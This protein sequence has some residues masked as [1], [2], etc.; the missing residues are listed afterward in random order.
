MDGNRNS[1]QVFRLTGTVDQ[2][3]RARRLVS[4]ALGREHPLHDDCVLLTSELATNAVVHSH[5][6]DG[7]VFT[8]TVS[9]TA[10]LVRVCVQDEGSAEPPCSC[11]A[12]AYAAGG[13]GLPLLEA[14]ARRWG[15]IREAGANSVWFEIAFDLVGVSAAAPNGRLLTW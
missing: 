1:D 11:G 4:G 12:N 9:H 7:G 6:G 13:R 15:L 10:D 14:L 8:L 2:V 3:G 5:S